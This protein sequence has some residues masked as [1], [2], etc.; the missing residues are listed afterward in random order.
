MSD[1]PKQDFTAKDADR[2]I[3]DYGKPIDPKRKE[4][5]MS[6]LKEQERG[7]DKTDDDK[8]SREKD[9]RGRER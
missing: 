9:P 1:I 5:L 3:R 8:T 4:A 2:L 7:V 6:K